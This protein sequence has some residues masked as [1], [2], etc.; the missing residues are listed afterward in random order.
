MAYLHKILAATCV[1]FALAFIFSCSLSDLGDNNSS[2]SSGGS[3]SSLSE[4]SVN[5]LFMNFANNYWY[6][7]AAS[8]QHECA[9]DYAVAAAEAAE[10]GY[11]FD[12]DY[13]VVPSCDGYPTEPQTMPFG[14]AGI[15]CLIKDY[16]DRDYLCRTVST[17][18]RCSESSLSMPFQ[19]AYETVDSCEGYSDGWEPL[20]GC[21]ILNPDGTENTCD[22]VPHKE[23]C[24]KILDKFKDGSSSE[25]LIDGCGNHSVG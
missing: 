15:G 9:H 16:N 20:H 2:S 4:E 11:Y 14:S 17:K 23:H 6:C 1:S 18:D 10:N 19:V 5:C 7:Y 22:L 3:S 25:F 21:L 12:T 13:E 24:D 8:G